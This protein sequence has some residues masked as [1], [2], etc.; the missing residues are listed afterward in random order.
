MD[1]LPGIAVEA[2]FAPAV[3]R[4]ARPG[5]VSR[6]GV[7]SR[8]VA[9]DRPGPV[10]RHGEPGRAAGGGR[11]PVVCLYTPS[12][13]PSGMGGHMIDLAA[14][15]VRQLDVTMMAWP[16]PA[17]VRLLE[18]AAAVGARPVALPHPRDPG[19]G[20][21]VAHDLRM[22][23]VDVFH[24]HVGTGRENF[25]GAR[26]A[27]CA[28]VPAVLQTL[29]LPWQMGSRKH[30]VP[31][32]A[33][34]EPVDRLVA[35]SELQRRSYERI[36]VP[37]E[38]FVTVPNGIRTRAGGPGRAAARAALGLHPAAR[39]VLTVG[40]LLHYKGQRHLIDAV[41]D[42]AARFPD[43]AVVVLGDG[44][45]HRALTEQAAALGVADR[46]HLPGFRPDARLLLDAAD[47]FVLPSRQEAMPLAALE[48]M[49]AGLPVVAS[50]VFGSAEVV[51]DGTT[52]LLVRPGDPRALGCAVAELLDDPE[53]ARRCGAAGRQRY[54][55]HY[56]SARMAAQ[57]LAV[58]R[59]VLARSP[60]RGSG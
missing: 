44:P 30:R 4:A 42:L 24:V 11:R 56:S 40:R 38:R 39:V 58:Y 21:A 41:P 23:P 45:L 52:G 35:V 54:L 20:N 51:V 34:I 18:L 59:A 8:P 49:D 37:A 15:Y 22:H 10:S 48:A 5:P 36:G 33:A 31:F 43:L 6:P 55:E 53:R 25:D 14:E 57:T 16:T 2:L 17:G 29:H 3:R 9:V 19:F 1:Q 60:A 27:G 50:R 32:F 26:A 13:D 46:V 47:V 12:A 7:V 28:G